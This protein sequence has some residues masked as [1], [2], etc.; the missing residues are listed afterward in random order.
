MKKSVLI[1]LLGLATASCV[2]LDV[3]PQGGIVTAERKEELIQAN[4]ELLKSSIAGLAANLINYNTLDLSSSRH[5]D[6]G[7]AA[8]CQMSDQSGQDMVTDNNG[9]NWFSG[10]ADFTNREF[11]SYENELIWK[12]FYNHIK[13]ANDIIELIDPAT[14]DEVFKGY[15][16]QAKSARAFAYLNL[17]QFFQLSYD[18]H[19]DAPAVPI[20]SEQTTFEEAKN[21]PRATVKEV[22]EFIKSDLDQAIVLLEDFTTEDKSAM[23]LNATYG[24]RARTNLLMHNYPQAATDAEKAMEGTSP[25]TREDLLV[26]AAN[27]VDAADKNVILANVI[28]LTN[29]VVTSGIIN[30]PSHLSS[31][32]GYGYTTAVQNF[33]RVNKAFFDQIPTTDVRKGWWVDENLQSP[34]TDGVMVGGEPIAEA[35]AYV[36]YTNVKFG[37]YTKV[38]GNKTNASDWI[39]MRTEE[40]ILI[41][42][43]ALAMEG[44]VSVAKQVLEDFIQTYRDSTFTSKATDA[45]QLVDEIYFQRRLELWGEGFGLKDILRLKKPV[46]RVD[47][48]TKESS[49]PTA[50]RINLEKEDP[51]LLFRV[52]Q[53]EINANNGIS[54][55]ENNTPVPAPSPMLAE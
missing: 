40:M 17:V 16:G 18:G 44:K 53:A 36:P 10:N 42:A 39:V 23:S 14:E 38:P 50:F 45:T 48:A 29:R 8:I 11:T 33:R 24:L 13:M 49:Y 46:V 54:E 25:Y 1:A 37:A 41:R 7:Y 9:Y 51:I 26:A 19:Q 3:K 15:L 21:N 32:T 2:D 20:V 47:E 4:P 28:T 12:L 31:M 34:I 55:S 5:Y 35:F 22:Y 30:W 27:F 6:Y 43:E 52:P